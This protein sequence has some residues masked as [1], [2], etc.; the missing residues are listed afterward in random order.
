M[1][2]PWNMAKKLGIDVA[3]FGAPQKPAVRIPGVPILTVQS[4]SVGVWTI[5]IEGWKPVSKNVKGKLGRWI[6]ARKRDDQVI[7]MAIGSVPKAECFRNVSF[8]VMQPGNLPDPQNLVESLADAL[9]NAGLLVDDSS[10]WSRIETA[11]VT[12]GESI[13]TVIRLEDQRSSELVRKS[14]CH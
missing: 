12:R 7:A 13:R 4:P 14:K 2:I 9:V 10:K 5:T 1:G 6:K 8:T 3:Q 11:R